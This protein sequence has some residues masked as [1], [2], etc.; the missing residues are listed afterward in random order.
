MLLTGQGAVIDTTTAAGK[1]VFGIFAAIA[2]FEPGVSRK[3]R[4]HGRMKQRAARRRYATS[5]PK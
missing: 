3:P 2:E 4:S 5:P 1:L